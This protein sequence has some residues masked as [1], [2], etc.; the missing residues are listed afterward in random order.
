ME[1][2]ICIKGNRIPLSNEL[3][4]L[5]Q[6]LFGNF[7]SVKLAEIPEGE[8]FK[9]GDYAFVVLQQTADGTAVVL[10]DPHPEG[11]RFGTNNNYD[12]SNVDD[13]CNKF[14]ESLASMIG[15]ES[16]IQH[17]VVLT[18]NDGLG[19]YGHVTR[20]ASLLT[21]EQ[22]RRYVRILDNYKPDRWWWLATPWSTETH[23]NSS[24]T[25]CVSPSGCI[26]FHSCINGDNGVRPFC[27]LKSDIFVSK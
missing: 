10:K 23:G 21:A 14:A 25:L 7:S 27:I 3:A 26:N 19:D 1:N 20:K 11:V 9:I 24:A 22:Y 12:G 18:S 13:C 15:D 6:K 5:A 4:K 16:I 17:E 2:Y 8:T